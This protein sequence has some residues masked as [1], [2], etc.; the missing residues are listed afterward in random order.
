MLLDESVLL[1]SCGGDEE[2]ARELFGEY[3]QRVTELVVSMREA[4]ATQ[5]VEEIRKAAHELKG[6]SLTLGASEMAQ[7]SRTIEDGCKAGQTTSLGDWLK[8]LEEQSEL[9]F[10]HLRIKGYL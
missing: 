9:L 8:H 2:F 1:Q 7:I 6:S 3:H 5:Q 4:Y 10:E